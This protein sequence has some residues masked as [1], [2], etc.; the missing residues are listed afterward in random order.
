MVFEEKFT[1]KRIAKDYL[2]IY[3]LLAEHSVN[4][5]GNHVNSGYPDNQNNKAWKQHVINQ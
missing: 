3:E 4:R 1:A 5:N 2:K